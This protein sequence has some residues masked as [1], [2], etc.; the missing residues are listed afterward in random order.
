[1]LNIGKI[2]PTIITMSVSVSNDMDSHK[3]W[4]PHPTKK[5]HVYYFPK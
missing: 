1:M 5:I 3:G 2:K 4:P